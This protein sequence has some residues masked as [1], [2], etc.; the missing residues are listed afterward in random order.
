MASD[1]FVKEHKYEHKF[2]DKISYIAYVGTFLKI[3]RPSISENL[4]KGNRP[5]DNERVDKM[6]K[7]QVDH[8][9]K[10]KYYKYSGIHSE[11]G[12][13]GHRAYFDQSWWCD[14]KRYSSGVFPFIGPYTGK[15]KENF[16]T[17]G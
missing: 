11:A 14:R 17:V 15:G 10:K 5:I 4:Y 8:Y 13:Y 16:T 9:A 6:Y 2:V 12:H 3:F 1:K 7:E